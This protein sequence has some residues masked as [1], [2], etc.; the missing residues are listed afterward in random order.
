MYLLFIYYSIEYENY[1]APIYYFSDMA[2]TLDY[3][4][5]S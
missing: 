1:E 4:N 5:H 2:E 3:A